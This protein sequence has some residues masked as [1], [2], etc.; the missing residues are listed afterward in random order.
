VAASDQCPFSRRAVRLL[1]TLGIPFERVEPIAG[2]SL[3]Q[4][5]IDGEFI[6]GY[7]ALVHCHATGQLD[8]LRLV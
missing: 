4:I 1:H 5:S 3:P 7:E 6:G 8:E 2:H